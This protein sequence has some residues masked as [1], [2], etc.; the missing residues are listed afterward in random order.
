MNKYEQGALAPEEK[1]AKQSFNRL[2]TQFKNIVL[3]NKHYGLGQARE[4]LESLPAF[5]AQKLFERFNEEE[6][7]LPDELAFEYIKLTYSPDE[8]LERMSGGEEF[9]EVLGAIGREL[10]QKKIDLNPELVTAQLKLSTKEIWRRTEAEKR[11]GEAGVK[12]GTDDLSPVN[13]SAA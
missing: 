11:E 2:F 4:I 10:K 1:E 3:A 7:A 6:G 8:I 12:E 5:E 9:H 13:G